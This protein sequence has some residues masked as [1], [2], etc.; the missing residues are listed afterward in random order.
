MT[1]IHWQNPKSYWQSLERY[2]HF[3]QHLATILGPGLVTDGHTDK[4]RQLIPALYLAS[5][6]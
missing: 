6:W 3:L 1:V 2:W 4:R 5:C